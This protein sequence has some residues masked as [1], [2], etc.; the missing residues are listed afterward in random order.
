MAGAV[1]VTDRLLP[2]VGPEMIVPF[3]LMVMNNGPV[4]PEAVA[5]MVSVAPGHSDVGGVIAQVGIGVP[6]RVVLLAQMQVVEALL[7]V[8]ESVTSPEYVSVTP[9]AGAV[10]VTDRLLPWVGPEIIVPFFLIVMNNGPVPPEA[11]AV[12]VSV[13]PGHSDAGGVISQVGIG[14]PD[15]VVDVSQ[16]QVVPAV[17]PEDE[18]VMCAE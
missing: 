5:V 13:E 17:L 8:D 4:P 18:S 11:V 16:T 10:A 2:W 15:R 14:V 9:E 3:F 7:P 6:V 12:M 1:A